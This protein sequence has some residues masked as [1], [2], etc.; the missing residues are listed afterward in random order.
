MDVHARPAE[1][2]ELQDFLRAFQVR[3]RRPEGTGALERYLT[4]RLTALPNHNGDT[5]AHAVPGTSEPRV[6][7]FLTNRPGDEHAR[8]RQRVQKMTAEAARGM[9]CWCWMIPA[10]PSRARPRWGAPGSTRARGAR[11]ATVRWR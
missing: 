2:P 10:F 4:G 9:A 5:I 7:E 6:Q 8:N 3:V 1:L 11:W